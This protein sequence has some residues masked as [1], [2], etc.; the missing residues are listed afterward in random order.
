MRLLVLYVAVV[1][2]VFG[3]HTFSEH[4]RF[5]REAAVADILEAL[6]ANWPIRKA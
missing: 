5:G 4:N 1:G 6:E 2:A 3:T